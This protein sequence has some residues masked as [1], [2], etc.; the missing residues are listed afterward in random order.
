M[1]VS[2][3]PSLDPVFAKWESRGPKGPTGGAPQQTGGGDHLVTN[4]DRAR[5]KWR[6]KLGNNVQQ[7]KMRRTREREKPRKVAISSETIISNTIAQFK[8]MPTVMP[9]HFNTHRP[10]MGTCCSCMPNSQKDLVVANTSLEGM[11]NILDVRHEMRGSGILARQFATAAYTWR[12]R[13]AHKYPDVHLA[14]LTSQR[15]VDAIHAELLAEE[16][17]QSQKEMEKRAKRI[18]DNMK[19]QISNGLTRFAVWFLHHFLS[20][21][22]GG[23]HVNKGQMKMVKAASQRGVPLLFLPLHKSHL[24]YILITFILGNFDIKNPNIAAG[25]NLNI[26]FFSYLMRGLGGYFIRRKLDRGDKKDSIYRAVLHSYMEQL[27]CY[28]E[29]MEFFLEGG[30]SRTGKALQPKGGL[31]SVIMDSLNNGVVED[32]YMV[33][34]SISYEKLLDGNFNPEHMGMP[35]KKESFWGAVRSIWSVMRSHYGNVRVDFA[36]PFSLRECVQALTPGSPRGSLRGSP[37]SSGGECSDPCSPRPLCRA[38]SSNTSL[39]GTDV[40]VEDERRVINNIGLHVLHT[41]VQTS[42]PMCTNLLAFLF[43]TKHRQGAT[44]EQLMSDFNWLRGEVII[45]KRDLGFSPNTSSKDVIMYAQSLL[46]DKLVTISR[47]SSSLQDRLTPCM[48]IPGMFELCYYSNQ[49]ISVFLLESIIV[50]A[51]VSLCDI[52]MSTLASSV[53]GEAILMTREEILQ[54]AQQLCDLLRYEFIFVPPCVELED[55]LADN[56]DRL[57]TSELLKTEDTQCSSSYDNVYDRQWASRLSDSLSWAQEDEE[58]YHEDQ[59]RVNIE[60]EDCRE[61]LQWFHS[62][63][64]PFFEAYLVTAHQVDKLAEGEMPEDDFMKTLHKQATTRVQDGVASYA[65]SASLETLRTAVRSYK[66]L[67]ILDNYKAGNVTMLELT[68][69]TDLLHQHIHLLQTLRG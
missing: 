5:Q 55:A 16:V 43:L 49:V 58:I 48:E 17:R 66:H 25:D 52:N 3:L 24:D 69:R 23:L 53:P 50:S 22:L 1:P 13:C 64:A 60:R 68:D 56:L 30:R 4:G 2:V 28:G 61:K 33:P 21:L 57:I 42:A 62:I 34:I 31:L 35:K 6:E 10:F 41:C 63:L 44:M 15:V 47:G 51:V 54:T 18:L 29:F 14:T 8:T 59:F 38:Y 12:I 46:G 11:R 19:S 67:N 32:V 65:E 45:R 7:L 26:P 36:Q 39:Y 37:E 20:L 40:V 9:E 27:L